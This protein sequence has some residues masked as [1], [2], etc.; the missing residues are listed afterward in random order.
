MTQGQEN[1]D[2]KQRFSIEAWM[3]KTFKFIIDP[4]AGFFL[5]IGLTPNMITLFGLLLSISSGIL[6]GFGKFTAAG[7]VLLVGA[8]LDV[9]DGAMARLRGPIT[10]FGAIFDSVIDRYSEV[11]VLAGLLV[12][13]SIHQDITAVILAFAAAAGSLLVSYVKARAE[14]MGLTAKVG[15]LTRV[16]RMILMILFLV[17]AKPVIGLWVIAILANLTALQRLFFV[18]KEAALFATPNA[19]INQIKEENR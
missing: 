14:G 12:Y 5:K 4:I 7:L 16:E 11:A 19:I 10:K 18:R 2:T 1:K 13:F 17:I 9:V 15:W 3:R 6:C 8:P